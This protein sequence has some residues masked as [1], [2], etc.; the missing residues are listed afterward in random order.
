MAWLLS[1][2]TGL[3]LCGNDHGHGLKSPKSVAGA[4]ARDTGFAW[5]RAKSQDL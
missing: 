4:E 3:R 5:R 2:Q 1:A